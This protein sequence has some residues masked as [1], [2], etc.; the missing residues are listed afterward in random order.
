MSIESGPR[1]YHD[2]DERRGYDAASMPD[3]APTYEEPPRPDH[4]PTLS[5]HFDKEDPQVDGG[6]LRSGR[7]RLL[8]SVAAGSVLVGGI[9]IG[10]AASGEKEEKR[11]EPGASAPAVPGEQSPS[12][13]ETDSG[14]TQFETKAE[15]APTIYDTELY[16]TLTPEQQHEVEK[17]DEMSYVTFRQLPY[18]RQLAYGDFYYRAYKEYG[19]EQ[20]K[21]SPYYQKDTPEVVDTGSSG[22]AILNDFAARQSTIFYSI[23]KN[24]SPYNINETNRQEAQ[25]ALSY[26]YAPGDSNIYKSRVDQLANLQNLEADQE[27][28][29]NGDGYPVRKADRESPAG[30]VFGETVKYI[31]VQDRKGEYDQYIYTFRTY[32][33][34]QGEER[35]TWQLSKILGEGHSQYQPDVESLFQ[36]AQ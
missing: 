19:M 15:Y 14:V 27:N 1:Q 10:V 29:Y 21:R 18:D 25:K 26:V 2:D 35:T 12:A 4:A 6:W 23:A 33:D 30:E 7:A 11:Q 5:G 31:N 16:K 28:H 20:V 17:L 22:Q 34:I 3:Q 9:F 32:T 36:Q 24:G 13:Q 8:A